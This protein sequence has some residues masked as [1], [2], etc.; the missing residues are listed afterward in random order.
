M[1]G[2]ACVVQQLVE[3]VLADH[4]TAFK[5]HRRVAHSCLLAKNRT[6]ENRVIPK[7]KHT[8]EFICKIF[9]AITDL[10][11]F[12]KSISMGSSSLAV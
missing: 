1:V 2:V 8:H 7:T 12:G 5:T 10:S 4:V 6:R 11:R 3:R 9:Q